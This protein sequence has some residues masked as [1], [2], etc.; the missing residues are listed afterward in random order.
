VVVCSLER[1]NATAA[2]VMELLERPTPADG[3]ARGAI[4]LDGAACREAVRG[5]AQR[6]TDNAANNLT[7]R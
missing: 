4:P 1:S 3:I 2:L 7:R 6:G 5:G